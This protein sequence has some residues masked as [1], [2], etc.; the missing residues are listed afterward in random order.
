MV[1]KIL[2]ANPIYRKT[3][4]VPSDMPIKTI[5][6]KSAE[7]RHVVNGRRIL[8]VGTKEI[9]LTSVDLEKSLADFGIYDDGVFLALY[10][11]PTCGSKE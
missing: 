8:Y 6:S 10:T 3:M 9:Q 11:V 1:L 7:P 2:V 5:I 4:I